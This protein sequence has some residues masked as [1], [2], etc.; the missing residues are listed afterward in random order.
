MVEIEL[1]ATSTTTSLCVFHAVPLSM[2]SYVAPPQTPAS[3]ARSFA[4]RSPSCGRACGSVMRYA[5]NF[6]VSPRWRACLAADVNTR[7]ALAY[8]KLVPAPAV[9]ITHEMNAA[10][11]GV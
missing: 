5:Q 2:L 8:S 11:H 9:F 1:P 10:L 3:L 7:C 4:T 6:D